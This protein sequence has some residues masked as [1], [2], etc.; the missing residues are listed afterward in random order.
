M[1][2]FTTFAAL[3]SAAA[4]QGP[5]ISELP[6]LTPNVNPTRAPSSIRDV[7][8][9]ATQS[10]AGPIQSGRAC[11]QIADVV[12]KSELQLPSVQAELALACLKSVPIAQGNA[13]STVDSLKQMVEF[14]STLS[15][16]KKPPKG[17]PNEAVDVMA[18]LDNIKSKVDDGGY[19]NE[20][21]F[22]N[23]IASL[24]V[25]AHDGHLAFNG[26]AYSGVFKWRRSRQVIPV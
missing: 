22:E 23:D 3:L 1:R 24:F 15:Y 20:Y 7:E 17:W 6:T 19:S 5:S 9:M 16:L 12:Q 26:M 21:D 13:S 2:A 18:G 11:A 8:P 10:L 25:K 14:Q 4:A